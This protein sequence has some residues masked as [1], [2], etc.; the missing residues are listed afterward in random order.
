MK[1][2]KHTLLLMLGASA[3]VTTQ[4]TS[5]G[6][7][8]AEGFYPAENVVRKIE[9][10]DASDEPLPSIVNL[11]SANGA[12][13]VTVKTTTRWS[14]EITNCDGQWCSI[15]NPTGVGEDEF[16]IQPHDN[17]SDERECNLVVSVVDKEGNPLEFESVM[18]SIRQDKREI[19]INPKSVS[20]ISNLE[21]K[22]SF[23]VKSN[24]DW[25][26]SSSNWG[27]DTKGNSFISVSDASTMQER[28][29][30]DWE[31]NG[32][33]TFTLNVSRNLQGIDRLARITI[34]SPTNAFIPINVDITQKA[35]DKTFSVYGDTEASAD[36]STLSWEVLSPLDGWKVTVTSQDNWLK[37]DK[38][39]YAD[40]GSDEL[41]IVKAKADANNGA[42]ARGATLRFRTTG[43]S[44][45]E[46]VITVT[47]AG[48]EDP[49]PTFSH[50]W[51]DDDWR[52]TYLIFNCYYRTNG[53]DVIE[54]GVDIRP[55]ASTDNDWTEYKSE[56]TE[57]NTEFGGKIKCKIDG[58]RGNTKYILR[59][60]ARL[61]DKAD[62]Y[63]SPVD[64]PV[65]T[66]FAWPNPE[67][68][69]TPETK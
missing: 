49:K 33:L 64:F 63:V 5:C 50:L 52:D 19:D 31:G 38:D 46:R 1:F 23:T 22:I 7:N 65:T 61:K 69:N 43:D 40:E 48:K 51:V 25:I 55:A 20:S 58:L 11:A 28:E 18:V 39:Y 2:P 17:P 21:S 9:L 14:A 67:D 42:I 34:S 24:L 10:F 37:L 47:Q 13:T 41:V 4:T 26:L 62:K 36:E 59:P 66:P 60:W 27:K 16:V 56:Y 12:F 30:G 53:A 32:E 29:N 54:T 45:E 15:E 6:D 44:P 8:I 35:A 57:E 3:L 68:N